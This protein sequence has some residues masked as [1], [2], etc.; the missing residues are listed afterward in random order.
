[1][2]H[3][4]K[5]LPSVNLIFQHKM[6]NKNEQPIERQIIRMLLGGY[7]VVAGSLTAVVLTLNVVATWQAVVLTTAFVW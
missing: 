2:S 7:F 5:K 4:S 3:P 1:M 6:K